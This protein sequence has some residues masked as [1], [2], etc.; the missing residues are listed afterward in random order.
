MG[1]TGSGRGRTKTSVA[2]CR[3]IDIGELCDGGRLAGRP[4]GEIR[5]VEARSGYILGRLSYTIAELLWFGGEVLLTLTL[6]YENRPGAPHSCTDIVLVGGGAG[7]RYYAECPFCVRRVRKLY[8][9]PGQEH[10]LCW[11][12]HGLVHRRVPALEKLA[13][14]ADVRAAIGSLW[15]GLY[16][17]SPAGE[18]PA[19]LKASSELLL[20]M[21][22]D[23]KPLGPQEL[24]VYCLRLAKAGYSLRRSAALVGISKSSVARIL[25]AGLG[26]VDSWAL[27]DERLERYWSLPQVDEEE[28]SLG[29]IC[30][31]VAVLQQRARRYRRN[32]VVPPE[33]EPERR[34]LIAQGPD[35]EVSAALAR[36]CVL[37]EVPGSLPCPSDHCHGRQPPCPRALQSAGEDT[38]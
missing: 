7:R 10:F 6:H 21:L 13:A 34:V 4:R 1:G 35:D 37:A 26:G 18:S 24:R 3:A 17:P 9:P 15:Q 23:E 16:R 8:A 36:R 11:R 38:V 19:A 33:G 5:W 31:Q 30:A 12:C 22:R 27:L 25:A 14:Q 32:R 28:D 2:D 29:L 20:G